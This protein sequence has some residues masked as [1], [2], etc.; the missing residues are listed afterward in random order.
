[1]NKFCSFQNT[2]KCSCTIPSASTFREK[3]FNDDEHRQTRKQKKAEA[4]KN[5]NIWLTKLNEINSK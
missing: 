2:D 1:M 4:A 3:Y 5:K